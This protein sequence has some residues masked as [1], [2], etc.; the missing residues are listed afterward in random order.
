LIKS[1]WAQMEK[2]SLPDRFNV[3]TYHEA[4]SR[5]STATLYAP[6]R[7]LIP[8]LVWL[9]QAGHTLCIRGPCPSCC[10]SCHRFTAQSQIMDVTSCLPPSIVTALKHSEQ[11]VGCLSVRQAGDT[12]FYPIVH[13]CP[14]EDGLVSAVPIP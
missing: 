12:A 1:I 4:M 5:V 10:R 3:M 9:R 11:S 14:T 7:F 2:V 6:Y 13:E 8:S